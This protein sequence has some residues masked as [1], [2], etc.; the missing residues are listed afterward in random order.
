M[1]FELVLNTSLKTTLPAIS[2]ILTVAFSLSLY[3]ITAFASSII[4]FGKTQ[5]P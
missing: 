3:E 1:N 4:G 5:Y 2:V